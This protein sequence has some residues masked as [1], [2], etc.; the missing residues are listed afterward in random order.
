MDGGEVSRLGRTKIGEA[1]DRDH[2]EEGPSSEAE[3]KLGTV[4]RALSFLERGEATSPPAHP[5]CESTM[6]GFD[7]VEP[8]SPP[9]DFFTN[10]LRSASLVGKSELQVAAPGAQERRLSVL[11]GIRSESNESNL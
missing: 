6:H 11:C 10:S 7:F 9:L 1:P 8:Y 5:K 4:R 2:G 3:S